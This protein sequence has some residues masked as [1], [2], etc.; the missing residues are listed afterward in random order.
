MNFTEIIMSV[1]NNSLWNNEIPQIIIDNINN[2]KSFN[3]NNSNNIDLVSLRRDDYMVIHSFKDVYGSNL[4]TCDYAKLKRIPC[5]L[6]NYFTIIQLPCYSNILYPESLI[7]SS[8]KMNILYNNREIFYN[9][10]RFIDINTTKQYL[11]LFN[12]YVRILR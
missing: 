1:T 6:R 11:L 7:I 4:D 12:D 8:D 3:N 2:S 9:E 5:K 10:I